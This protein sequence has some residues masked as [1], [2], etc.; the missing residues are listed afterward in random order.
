MIRNLST[1]QMEAAHSDAAHL[2]V[3]P[4]VSIGN[5]RQI[6]GLLEAQLKKPEQNYTTYKTTKRKHMIASSAENK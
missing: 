5:V 2:F 6:T 3:D 1:K 4:T